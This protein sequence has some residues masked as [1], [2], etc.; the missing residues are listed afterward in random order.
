MVLVTPM[1]DRPAVVVGSLYQRIY[2][3]V[4]QIPL[5]KV[6]TYGQ[7]AKIVGRCSPRSVGYAMAAVP[8]GTDIPW[9]RVINSQG[10]VSDRRRG[11]GAARQREWLQEEGVVFD[12]NGI[13]DLSRW[14]W[15]GPKKL[16]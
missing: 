2:A 7:I 16:G 9:Q 5:G 1:A 14:H 12:E 15:R 13:V 8:F 4:D 11:Q 10:K 6:A 3:V